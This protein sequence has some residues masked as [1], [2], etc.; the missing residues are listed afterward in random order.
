MRRFF[1]A[2]PVPSVSH[3]GSAC[4]CLAVDCFRFS[5]SVADLSHMLL[6]QP[7]HGVS[8]LVFVS[9]TVSTNAVW[10]PS[11]CYRRFP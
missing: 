3:P 7:A 4:T 1:Y 10:V 11:N 5:F 9:R 6:S 2:G 8:G